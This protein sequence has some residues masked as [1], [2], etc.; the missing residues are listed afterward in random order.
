[1]NAKGHLDLSNLISSFLKD[2]TCE[3]ISPP[4]FIVPLGVSPAM[5]VPLTGP[6]TSET[7]VHIDQDNRISDP[8]DVNLP[9]LELAI[10]EDQLLADH[11]KSWPIDTRTWRQDAKT[12]EE[13]AEQLAGEMMPGLWTSLPEYP[14]LPRLSVLS[15]WNSDINHKMPPFYPTCLSTRAKDE[16]WQLT[17]VRSEGWFTWTHPEHLDKPYLTANTTGARVEFELR[18]EVGVVKMYS[19]RSRSFGLGIIE[20]WVDD[21]REKSVKIDG[22]W[23]NDM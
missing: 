15:G 4:D 9:P 2:V 7:I 16:M 5:M 11:Q 23:D 1:M 3:M 17:P 18:T 14:L 13:G 21:E 19:L 6:I 8:T 20:C 22:F 12:P 10:L